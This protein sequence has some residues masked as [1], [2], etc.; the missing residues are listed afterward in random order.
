MQPASKIMSDTNTPRKPKRMW[1]EKSANYLLYLIS[2]L[3]VATGFILAYRLPHG[4]EAREWTVMGMGRHDWGD[5][6]LYI[7]FSFIALIL[8][9]LYFVRKWLIR[10]AVKRR[11]WLLLLSLGVG[12][13]LVLG[14]LFVPVAKPSSAN[15]EDGLTPQTTLRN[16]E[17]R[18]QGK[19]YGGGR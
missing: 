12:L 16:G 17:G 7:G 18:G 4:R 14:G 9:H 19:G 15:Q 3:L 8:L 13:A 6:H 1:L 10:V 5:W 11:G 2:C